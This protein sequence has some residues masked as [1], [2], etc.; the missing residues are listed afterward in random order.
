MLNQGSNSS[1]P[2]TPRWWLPK[3]HWTLH[4]S[5]LERTGGRRENVADLYGSLGLKIWCDWELLQCSQLSSPKC[6]GSIFLNVGE[7]VRYN[8]CGRHL[9]ANFPLLLSHWSCILTDHYF[10]DLPPPE[11]RTVTT[12]ISCEHSFFLFNL[13]LICWFVLAF[14]CRFVFTF[15]GTYIFYCANF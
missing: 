7:Y 14:L 1:I 5:C 13:I 8:D 3:G 12:C 15:L 10:R 11:T 6:K 2:S 9:S 4:S